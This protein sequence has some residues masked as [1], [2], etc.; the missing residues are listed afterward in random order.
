MVEPSSSSP[1]RVKRRRL[2]LEVP[3]APL[4]EEA[5]ADLATLLRVDASRVY[6]IRRQHGLFAMAD[7]A[8]LVA[9][10]PDNGAAVNGDDVIA[11][12][13]RLY[14][15]C[16]TTWSLC[17]FGPPMPT[18]NN[19]GRSL[20]WAGGVL[21]V[22]IMIALLPNDIESSRIIQAFNRVFMQESNCSDTVTSEQD[23]DGDAPRLKP[24]ELR[25]VQLL[26]FA[27]KSFSM[28]TDALFKSL[29]RLQE[30]TGGELD[31]THRRLQ[32]ALEAAILQRPDIFAV[33]VSKKATK[34]F[35]VSLVRHD[36]ADLLHG[37]CLLREIEEILL[38]NNTPEQWTYVANVVRSKRFTGVRR[39]VE[40]LLSLDPDGPRKRGDI[41][42]GKVLQRLVESTPDKWEVKRTYSNALFRLRLGP[43]GST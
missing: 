25:Q 17:L 12:L 36:L 39:R 18:K 14:P 37:D 20:A 5:L 27:K 34:S 43:T 8:S 24:E 3:P 13:R 26:L 35:R 6:A 23:G 9:K 30:G 7:V 32:G 40:S 33:D 42:F 2:S 41:K 31:R 19:R 4:P 28:R 22:S 21:E 16:T 11:E 1:T 15:S 38:R 10:S 29:I